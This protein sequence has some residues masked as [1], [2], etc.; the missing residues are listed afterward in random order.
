MSLRSETD[1]YLGIQ[2]L[3][4]NIDPKTYQIQASFQS[5]HQCFSNH[6]TLMFEAF[7]ISFQ[8]LSLNETGNSKYVNA[9]RNA[10]LP[11]QIRKNKEVLRS[12]VSVS[13]N[14]EE[15]ARDRQ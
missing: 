9:T 10:W 1:R 15:N 7:S 8:E 2:M 13:L 14:R 5:L 11:K 12:K 3:M 4:I 6:G